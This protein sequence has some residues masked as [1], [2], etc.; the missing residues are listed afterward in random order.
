[1]ASTGRSRPPASPVL[2]RRAI[3]RGLAAA[4]A[5]ALATDA[6]RAT[7]YAS[8]A[9]V[10]AAVDRAEIEVTEQLRA[11]GRAMPSAR[12]FTSSLLADLERHRA[13]RAALCRRLRL[14]IV[15]QPAGSPDEPLSLEGLRSAQESLL[16]AHAEGL[17][18]VGLAYAI[19]VLANH[20]VDLS[21]H[22]TVTTL[23]IEVEGERG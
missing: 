19:D 11:L 4:P 9:E 17:P 6:V 3:V 22:L 15:A 20:L 1:L 10:F 14:Q 2:T 7:D 23:W 13:A 8:A 16:Y 21:R 18:A 5:L 12:A